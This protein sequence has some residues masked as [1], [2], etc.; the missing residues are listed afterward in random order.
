MNIFNTLRKVSFAFL[1]TL[2]SMNFATAQSITAENAVSITSQVTQTQ[3]Q[4]AQ[5]TI[6]ATVV[7]GYHIYA[8]SQEK[9]FTATEFEFTNQSNWKLAGDFA[10]SQKPEIKNHPSIPVEL[11][12]LSHEITWTAPIEF[13]GKFDDLKIE[14]SVRAQACWDA[15]CL[16]PNNYDFESENIVGI[17][18]NAATEK[19]ESAFSL[20]NLDIESNSNASLSIWF[21]LPTA[22]LAG[23]L[24]NFM[25]C[26]L[27]VIGLKIM[28]FVQQAGDNRGR[29]FLLNLSYTMGLLSVMFVLATLAVFAGIG[30]GEQFSSATF[31]VFLASAVFAFALSFLGV[32]DIPIP[33]FSGTESKHQEGLSSAFSK[34]ILATLL[35]TPC[36]GPFLGSALTW[37]VSQSPLLTYVTFFVVGLGMAS[38][39]LVIGAF[40]RLVAFLPKPGAWMN[41]FKQIM[42]FVL[43]ATV[44]YL[45][46]FIS[47]PVVVP[48][49]ALMTGIAVACWWVGKTPLT[50]NFKAQTKA[51]S[52][53]AVITAASAFVAFG[54]LQD[55]MQSR[56][57]RAAS[58]YV[59]QVSGEVNQVEVRLNNES[60]SDELPWQN[61]SPEVLEQAVAAGKT[62]FIDFTADWCL[63]CKANEAT[64]VEQDEVRKLVR[65]NDVVVLRAD[66]T[67]PAP[68]V[69]ETLRQLGNKAGSIPFYA[70]FSAENPNQPITLDGLLTSPK[71]IVDALKKAGPSKATVE[72]QIMSSKKSK[73]SLKS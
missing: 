38:P 42:G 35:A 41:T 7:D 28:S 56:F 34:G 18:A 68:E 8:M 48:T 60:D 26:V 57:E 73:D 55:V 43:L 46:S 54:W 19:T 5:L 14:G 61:F 11:H 15:G 65:N 22:F 17:L 59:A 30:W 47:I 32:W 21:V 66:K 12:W 6:T 16:P 58:R 3:T 70:V 4:K 50:A 13:E 29:A 67:D 37:A 49:I 39:Y 45:L 25:P 27:P 40:P 31:N 53:A 1:L 71:P 36:S 2:A 20:S 33:G 72:K 64:A 62:V 63:T 44:V 9:P 23:F 10:A 51:Y 24:L 52:T 69:D